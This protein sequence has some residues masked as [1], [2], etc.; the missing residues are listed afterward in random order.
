MV[1]F[2][3]ACLFCSKPHPTCSGA[4]KQKDSPE[5]PEGEEDQRKATGEIDEAQE[6]RG[7]E[8]PPPGKQARHK[9]G[10]EERAEEETRKERRSRAQIEDTLPGGEQ[11]GEDTEPED[12]RK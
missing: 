8:A 3:S 7:D 2:P 5:E 10:P 6:D 1:D 12:H 4:H 9:Y 11:P